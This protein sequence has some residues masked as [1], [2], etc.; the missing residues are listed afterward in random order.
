MEAQRMRAKSILCLEPKLK[1]WKVVKLR[2][3]QI[4]NR[5]AATKKLESEE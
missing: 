4:Q 2:E 3:V 1:L 5:I